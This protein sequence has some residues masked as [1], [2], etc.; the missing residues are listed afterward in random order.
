MVKYQVVVT[1]NRHE[2]YEIEREALAAIGAEL[3]ICNCVTPADVA[4]ECEYADGILLDMAPMDRSAIKRLKKCKV[5]NRYGVGYDNVDVEAASEQGIQVTNVPDYCAEDVS[6]HALALLMT[7]LRHTAYRDRMV[8]SGKWNLQ[9]TSFRM[10]GKVL[11]VLGFGRIARALVAKCSGFGF[12]KVLVYDPYISE[13]VCQD[14]GVIKAEL[15]EVLRDADFV[16][17]HM[18]VT[19]ETKGMINKKTLS[20]MKP[21]AILV[22]T[23]RGP[24]INDRDLIEALKEQR[25]LAAGLDTHNQEPL[26]AD[27]AYF[28]LDNVVVTDHTAYSTVE[29][30]RELKEKS[31]QNVIDVMTGKVPRYPVNKG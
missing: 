12:S 15:T 7:C 18:P 3:K 16:S 30:V 17:L 13:K 25:I 19:P 6:D 5:I 14:M 8:R 29:A 31:V 23:G 2:N 22:N 27:C 28:A 10:R 20:Y 21:T 24:L 4:R 9:R 1:D 26:P 11:G